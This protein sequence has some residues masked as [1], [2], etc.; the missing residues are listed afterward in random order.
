MKLS[1][2]DTSV[3]QYRRLDGL[4]AFRLRSRLMIETATTFRLS[5]YLRTISGHL[6]LSSG[7]VVL[8]DE[9]AF[10][11][12]SLYR[13]GV[14]VHDFWAWGTGALDVIRDDVGSLRLDYQI[15]FTGHPCEKPEFIEMHVPLVS[16]GT[17]GS[18]TLDRASIVS[19]NELSIRAP[20]A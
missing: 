11:E 9:I 5:A 2:A 12:D 17:L 16:R 10:S 3:R 8:L 4:V 14:M 1:L 15:S 18:R 20:G 13:L 6:T 19:T 7:M